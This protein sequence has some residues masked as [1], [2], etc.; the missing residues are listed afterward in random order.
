MKIFILVLLALSLSLQAEEHP[1]YSQNDVKEITERVA[2]ELHVS[3]D[4]SRELPVIVVTETY[5]D[6]TVEQ[7]YLGLEI[8]GSATNW[9]I[10][11]RNLVL[12]GRSM[13]RDH[14]AHELVHYIQYTYLDYT[15]PEDM[16]SDE[17]ESTAIRIQDLFR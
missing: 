7:D 9:Y 16:G 2:T 10:P 4:P 3:L 11:Q 12:L 14:L 15:T 1:A 13:T 8:T 17:A 5:D 6:S